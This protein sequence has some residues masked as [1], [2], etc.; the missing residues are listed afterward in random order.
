M[1]VGLFDDADATCYLCTPIVKTGEAKRVSPQA[2]EQVELPPV[3]EAPTQPVE[4]TKD[5]A[6]VEP[7]KEEGNAQCPD[8]HSDGDSS[9]PEGLV[10]LISVLYA[11]LMQVPRISFRLLEVVASFA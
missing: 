4:P 11:F 8:N 1:G 7:V 5:E 2:V 10:L 3:Q 6:S 9:Q